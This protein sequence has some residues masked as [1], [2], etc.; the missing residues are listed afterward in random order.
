[1]NKPVLFAILPALALAAPALAQI[2]APSANAEFAAT[3][4]NLA[5]IGDVKITPDRATLNL[6]VNVEAPTAAEAMRQNATQMAAVIAALKARGVQDR[7]IRT[8]G[9]NLQTQ[10]A[11]N[12]NQP[13]RLT[14]YRA[15]NMVTVTVEDMDKVGALLDAAVTAGANQVNGINF[16]LKNAAAAEDQARAEAIKA[17]KAKAEVYAQANGMRVA[18]LVRMSEGPGAPVVQPFG[19][20][21]V[22]VTASRVGAAPLPPVSAGEMDVRVQVNAVYELSR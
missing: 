4:V 10:Y 21:E 1:M 9:L 22:V 12:Q 18:R 20:Q 6:G 11:Y 2:Q 15:T 19:V 7:S 14:G 3:T 5:A 16:S 13:P 8:Q 17:V